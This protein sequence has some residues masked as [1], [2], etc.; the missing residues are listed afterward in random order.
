[1]S[2]M[3]HD[4]NWKYHVYYTEFVGAL[5]LKPF[6]PDYRLFKSRNRGRSL[7][8][9]EYLELSLKPLL[10]EYWAKALPF[11]DSELSRQL[12]LQFQLWFFFCFWING[13]HEVGENYEKNGMDYESSY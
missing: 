10:S 12:K 3:S 9:S 4:S 1:M 6:F 8:L 11:P 5:S 7:P 2:S 13:G